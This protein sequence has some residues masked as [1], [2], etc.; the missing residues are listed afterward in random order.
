[1]KI[2]RETRRVVRRQSP[3]LMSIACGTENPAS[4]GCCFYELEGGETAAVFVPGKLHESHKGIMHGGLSASVI[5]EVMGRTIMH[6]ENREEGEQFMCM[7]AE[8]AVKYRKPVLIEKPAR[9]YGRIKKRDGVCIHV[10]ADIVDED[11]EI[12]AS[13]EGRF[14]KM[15]KK[16][17]EGEDRSSDYMPLTEKD[18]K[19]L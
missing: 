14:I 9:A 2:N 12:L 1:M 8:M 16:D 18:P 15:T 11:D 5:D 19:E 3:S 4:I 6:T 17:G 10:T 7:T 13:G